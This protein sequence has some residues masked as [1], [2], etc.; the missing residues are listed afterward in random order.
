MNMDIMTKKNE[1]AEIAEKYGL[2]F[3]VLFGSQATG[4]TH[5]KSDVDIGLHSSPY[6]YQSK[7]E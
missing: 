4:R 2:D 7:L 5:P 1:M 6:S 3:I